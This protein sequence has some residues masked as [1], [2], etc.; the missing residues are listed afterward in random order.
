[1]GFNHPSYIKA[2]KPDFAIPLYEKMIKHLSTDFG[3][4][5]QTGEFEADMKVELLND[6]PVTIVIHTK[7]KE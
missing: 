5:I 6:W 4:G 7:R 1:L 3:K 2:N